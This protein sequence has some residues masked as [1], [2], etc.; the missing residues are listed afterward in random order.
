MDT[1]AIF[2]HEG[3]I[4]YPIDARRLSPEEEASGMI[5]QPDGT[6]TPASGKP[7]PV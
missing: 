3:T 2:L 5:Q 4:L 6:F 1:R 7:V